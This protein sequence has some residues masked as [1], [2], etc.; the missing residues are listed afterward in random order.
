[1]HGSTRAPAWARV[2]IAL[3]IAAIYSFCFV[4]IKAGLA[5]APPLLFGGL[6]A[7]IAGL[8]LLVLMVA[9]RQRVLPASEHWPRIVT[10]GLTA[11]TIAFGAMF[12]SPGRAGA[13]IAS[14]LGNLQ[15]LIVIGLAAI[16]LQERVTPAKWAALALG[17]LGVALIASPSLSG[18]DA[19]RVTGG[20][21]ALAASGGLAAGNVIVKRL[22]ADLSLLTLTAWQLII[23]SL[24]LLA[25]SL[26]IE[27]GASITWNA[28]F[29]G[30]LLFLALIGT[31]LT[32]AAWYWLIQGEEV[33]RVTIFLFLVPVFGLV[34]AA[35]IFG[36]QI[37]PL[38]TAGIAMIL[39]GVGAVAWESVRGPRQ[40]HGAGLGLAHHVSAPGP[41]TA[42]TARRNHTMSA[43]S[44]PS[45]ASPRKNHGR[46]T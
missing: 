34:L 20:L 14:V 43:P 1:M 2:C 22:G 26:V 12:L 4:S 29:V 8:A 44:P 15:P 23:G 11:T 45:A 9:L 35:L 30:L 21:L 41:P 32:T 5:F 18:P 16:F 39:A 33:G 19:H 40:S 37:T 31:S 42:L 10:L 46:A 24:V 3:G 7:L 25:G 38:E 27:P 13:G 6:R 17:L 36:E 28:E